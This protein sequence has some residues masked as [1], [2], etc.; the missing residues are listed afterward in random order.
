MAIGLGRMFGFEFME[1]FDYPY[2]SASVTE[3]WRRWHISLGSWFRDY[4]YIPLGGNRKHQLLNLFVVWTLTGFWHGASWNYL[5]WGF[6]YF[7][8]LAIE[9]FVFKNSLEKVPVLNHMVT[10]LLVMIGWEIFYFEDISLCF[11]GLKIMLGLGGVP[12][13]DPFYTVILKNRLPMLLL[14]CV[15]CLPIGEQIAK[16]IPRL[17]ENNP[18]IW[19][20]LTLFYQGTT[21][22]LTVSFLVSSTVNPFLYFR[23]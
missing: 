22:F 6:Y 15:L 17:R 1:N 11:A 3:F 9:K 2:I 7:V 8:L 10:L 23:F 13:W 19:F 21:L 5:L 18:W 12:L 14:S 16:P 4:V 20:F